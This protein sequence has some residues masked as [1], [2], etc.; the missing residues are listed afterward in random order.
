MTSNSPAPGLDEPTP[1]PRP[2]T[3]G[4]AESGFFAWLRSL[5]VPRQPGWLGGVCAGVAA[6]LGIDPIIVR[7]I[8][9]VFALF[10]SPVLLAY[11]VAWL[12]LPDATGRIH[13]QELL[14][15]VFD[16]AI[17]G[18]AIL[19]IFGVVPYGFG[20]GPFIGGL[21]DGAAWSG[22][23]WNGAFGFHLGPFV[24]FIVLAG[25]ITALIV[26]L[27]RRRDAT[28]MSGYGSAGYGPA[29]TTTDAAPPATSDAGTTEALAGAAAATPTES[30]A[31][32]AAAPV[33]PT[34]PDAA[35]GADEYVAWKRQHDEWR[36]DYDA[37]KRSQAE[38]DR[39][40]RAQ[41]AARNKAQA[42]EFQARAIEARRTRR[43]TRPRIN[44]GYFIAVLGA[45]LIAG[46][47]GGII[48]AG[49]ASIAP[50]TWTVSLAGAALVTAAGMVAAGI[51]RRRSGWLAFVTIALLVP[52]LISGAVPRTAE[53]RFGSFDTSLTSTRSIVQPLG[54]TFL[55]VD[56]STRKAAIRPRLELTQGAGTVYAEVSD[57]TVLSIDAT[58]GNGS[59][60]FYY[61]D[62]A[63]NQ[64]FEKAV[65]LS[66]S[67]T[68]HWAGWKGG[69]GVPHAPD[70][71]LVVRGGNTDITVVTHEKAAVTNEESNK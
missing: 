19:I 62:A 60:T 47:I 37:W 14:R 52:A 70:A 63:G 2:T 54:S 38:S 48:A 7:G 35:V 39:A 71:Q 59:I 27:V 56:D 15:G 13:L 69:G 28:P 51:A 68:D 32:D 58:V 17:V 50:Y 11:G 10:G 42:A 12:L 65:K 67:G 34:R 22:G 8:V 4:A 16:S 61:V 44:F 64:T 33:E 66:G 45:A 53:L 36:R 49:D 23:V 6:R 30:P 20:I 24:T 21:G 9:V 18:I 25:A 41:L 46:A 40:A 43:L 31:S 1:D 55:T 26:W 5:R 57:D 29:E 3:G